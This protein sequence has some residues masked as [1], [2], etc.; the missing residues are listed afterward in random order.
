MTKIYLPVFLLGASLGSLSVVATLLFLRSV[1]L[2]ER[3]DGHLLGLLIFSV[4]LNY[5]S[6]TL[7]YPA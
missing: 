5:A 6:Q 2:V 4:S 3:T 7:K 1:G